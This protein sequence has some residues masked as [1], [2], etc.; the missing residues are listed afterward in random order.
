M[1]EINEKTIIIMSLIVVGYGL[2]MRWELMEFIFGVPMLV[3]GGCVV[4]YLLFN[5]KKPEEKKVEEQPKI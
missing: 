5:N 4:S 3:F 2:L 1:Y